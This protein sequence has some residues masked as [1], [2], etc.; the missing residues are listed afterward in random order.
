M[1]AAGGASSEAFRTERVPV[2]T[3][4][5]S[6]SVGL[7]MGVNLQLRDASRDGFNATGHGKVAVFLGFF[8]LPHLQSLHLLSCGQL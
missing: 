2:S 4:G 3:A 6:C 1:A 8:L 7:V 5:H